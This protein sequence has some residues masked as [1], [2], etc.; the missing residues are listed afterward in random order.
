MKLFFYLNSSFGH[1]DGINTTVRA[2]NQNFY[3][4][5]AHIRFE[6]NTEIKTKSADLVE[7]VRLS[8]FF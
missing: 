7:K 5:D 3:L 8:Y 6:R 4:P 1:L 2:G